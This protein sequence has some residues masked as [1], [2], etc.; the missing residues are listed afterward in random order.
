MSTNATNTIVVDK[1]GYV[2]RLSDTVWSFIKCFKCVLN[3]GFSMI[4]NVIPLKMIF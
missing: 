3:D 1:L 4:M 2:T